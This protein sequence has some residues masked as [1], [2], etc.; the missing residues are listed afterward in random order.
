[1]HQTIEKMKQLRLHQMSEIHHQ[2][3]V[4]NHHQ[5]YSVDQY[6]SFLVEQEWEYR[7]NRKIER[8]I[9][10]A[11]FKITATVSDID[12]KSKRNLD[13]DMI[14]K[15]ALL[16]F[17]KNKQNIIFTG[18]AGVGKSYLA[19]ALGH[20]ACMHGLRTGYHHCARLL[21]IM[22]FA[23]VEGSYLKQL[24]A[25]AKINLLILDDF[26]LQKLDNAER[27]ILMDI[28]E[29]RHQSTSTIIASQ[30]PISKWYDIIGEGTIADAILDRLVHTAYRI[31]LQGESQ[32][33]KQVPKL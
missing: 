17:I 4:N 2:R 1:M 27:E 19:Q 10:T 12:F 9:R 13:R 20:Q 7:R 22:K 26:G 28:I 6:T 16:S 21:A 25:I 32:R 33:K 18:P 24:A 23:K 15:L 29:D 31:D 30:I 8:L 3:V 5:D 11:K 14:H